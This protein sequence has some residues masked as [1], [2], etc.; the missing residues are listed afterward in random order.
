METKRR[1]KRIRRNKSDKEENVWHVHSHIHA[2]Q[3]HALCW[4]IMF[5]VIKYK[6]HVLE[7]YSD[8]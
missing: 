1:V 4:F 3:N 8:I 2:T 7:L 6:I 5:H